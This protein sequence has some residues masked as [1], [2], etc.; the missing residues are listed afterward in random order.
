MSAASTRS[1]RPTPSC[2]TRPVSGGPRGSSPWLTSRRQDGAAWAGPGRPSREPP[3]WSRS[4][5]GP[6][7]HRVASP[8][9]RWPPPWPPPT[10]SSRWPDSAPTSSGPT[11]LSSPT[12]SWPGSWPSRQPKVATPPSSWAS[13]STCRPAPTRP[14]WPGRPPAARRRPAGRST[15]PS[16]SSPSSTPSSAATPPP[17]APTAPRR[18]WPSTGPVRPPWAG[19]CGSSC[20][21]GP[22]S[23]AWPAR[24]P[25][26]AS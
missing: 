25:G 3:S 1:A 18:P 7:S 17:P 11:I 16:C 22:C 2:S 6:G 13:G 21:T 23:K 26:T 14:S 9:S 12:R 5:S 19:G 8:P 24:S 4:S 15:G 10:A 20:P